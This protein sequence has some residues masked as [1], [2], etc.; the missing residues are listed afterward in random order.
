MEEHRVSLYCSLS[1]CLSVL[2]ST[3]ITII[4]LQTLALI[5]LSLSHT[6]TYIWTHVW[7]CLIN[8]AA[9]LLATVML[10]TCPNMWEIK[11]LLQAVWLTLPMTV[12]LYIYF[13]V[14]FVW[15]CIAIQHKYLYSTLLYF[16]LSVSKAINL[17][18]YGNMSVVFIVIYSH[19]H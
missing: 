10:E 1:L 12:C 15:K 7:K 19:Y 2:L 11:L 16:L 4:N 18:A 17:C 14:V 8:M 3:I 5:T 9:S 13:G 6:H